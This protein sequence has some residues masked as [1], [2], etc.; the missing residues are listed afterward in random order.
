MRIGVRGSGGDAFCT[1]GYG[2][3]WGTS[4]SKAGRGGHVVR[5]SGGCCCWMRMGFGLLV[6]GLLLLGLFCLGLLSLGLFCMGL[7]GGRSGTLLVGVA[8]HMEYSSLMIAG[9]R[10]TGWLSGLV[11][12]SGSELLPRGEEYPELL[13]VSLWGDVRLGELFLGGELLKRSC[14]GVRGPEPLHILGLTFSDL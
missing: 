3:T 14:R 10:M 6:L 1:G 11:G 13:C 12:A 7:A 2:S 4:C 8:G 5:P 9:H